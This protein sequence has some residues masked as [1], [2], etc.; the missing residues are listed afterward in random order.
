MTPPDPLTTPDLLGTEPEEDLRDAVAALLADRCTPASVLARC[1]SGRP[2]D[3]ELWRTLAVQ[4]GVSGL[5]VPEAFGGQ[6]GTYRD[7]AVVAGEL[8]RS[9]APLPFL[10]GCVLAMTTLLGCDTGDPQVAELI[11]RLASTAQPAA[12]AVPLPSGPGAG[13]P[14]SVS[15]TG[16]GLLTGRIGTVADATVAEVLLVPALAPDGPALYAVDRAFPGLTLSPLTA[17]DLTRGIGDVVL[18][19]APGMRVAGPEHA[20]GAVS[21]ALTAA[22]AVLASEQVGIAEWCL[23]TTVDHVRGRHQFGR[24]IGSFQ[25]VKHRLADLWLDLTTARA[26]ARYAA[27]ALASGSPDLPIAVALAQ[28]HCGPIAVRAAEEC[29]QLHGGMGMT[30]EHPAHLYLA[31]AKSDEIALGSPGWHRAALAT[32]VDL[33]AG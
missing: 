4:L 25:A 8:G 13:F 29:I 19:D 9:V 11:E 23:A 6:G 28:A 27:D 12:L 16:D 14:G 15:A 32:L 10:G 1:E 3:L 26:T 33:P 21:G 17:L 18:Y 20:P 31:R 7:T 2:Y 5:H 30:W 22:A 24:P